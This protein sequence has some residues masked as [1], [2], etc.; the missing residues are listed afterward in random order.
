LIIVFICKRVSMTSSA[1][2]VTL[3][4]LALLASTLHLILNE[5]FLHLVLI[6]NIFHFLG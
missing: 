4:K 5:L 2:V 1:S 3:S 6:M